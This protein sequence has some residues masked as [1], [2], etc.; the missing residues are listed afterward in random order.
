MASENKDTKADL[1]EGLFTDAAKDL[2]VLVDD[3][4]A[5]IAKRKAAGSSDYA[6][7]VEVTIGPDGLRARYKAL[8][9]V[10]AAAVGQTLTAMNTALDDVIMYM[11]RRYGGND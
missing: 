5:V 8:V 2:I 6:I 7:R 1:G 9:R 11:S 4:Y 10:D 3:V